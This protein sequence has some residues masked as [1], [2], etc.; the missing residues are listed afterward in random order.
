MTLIYHVFPIVATFF[1]NFCQ[2]ITI[3]ANKVRLI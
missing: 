1:V 2:I 3:Y